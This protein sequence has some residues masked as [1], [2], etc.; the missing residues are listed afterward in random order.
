M[1]KSGSHHCQFFFPCKLRW[2]I[3]KHMEILN[4]K[5]K[6]S[7]NVGKNVFSGVKRGYDNIRSSLSKLLEILL[8][9][10]QSGC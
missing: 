7:L 5:L 4:P 10:E 2:L 6:L 9:T 8:W 1:H 3:Q